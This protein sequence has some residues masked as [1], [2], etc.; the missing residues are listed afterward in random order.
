MDEILV[1]ENTV[2]FIDDGDYMDFDMGLK[3]LNIKVE[4]KNIFIFLLIK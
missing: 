1:E 3:E 4:N 2:F